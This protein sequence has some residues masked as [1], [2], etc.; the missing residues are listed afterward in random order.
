M[1]VNFW[2]NFY[3]SDDRSTMAAVGLH[4]L[5]A[6]YISISVSLICGAAAFA[7]WA[8]RFILS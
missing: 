3:T 8:I 4:V 5:G 2:R 1:T 7:K 6:A